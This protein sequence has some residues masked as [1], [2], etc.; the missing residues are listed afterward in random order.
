M[1]T[2]LNDKVYQKPLK[3]WW[4]QS[5]CLKKKNLL[6]SLIVQKLV[7]QFVNLCLL[8]ELFPLKI[9]LGDLLQI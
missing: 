3:S 6:L 1:E 5:F 8:L 4:E 2:H 9:K 7:H